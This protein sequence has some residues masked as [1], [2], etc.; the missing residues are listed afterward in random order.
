MQHF[1]P[2]CL[3]AAIRDGYR[4]EF[5]S[6]PPP[7]MLANNRSARERPDF[8]EAEL[9]RLEK[10]GCIVKVDKKPTVVNPLSVVCEFQ[11][12]LL[13]YFPSLF[14]VQIQTSGG[15]SLTAQET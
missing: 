13:S 8:V 15:L 1:Y 14:S 7:S 10:L 3:F 9:A 5:D 6:K 12:Q 2:F 4:L 11:L